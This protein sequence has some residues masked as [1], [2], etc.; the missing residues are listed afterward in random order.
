MLTPS[1]T[2]RLHLSNSRLITCTATILSSTPTR[3]VLEKTP[4][5]HLVGETGTISTNSST[6][7]VD[8]IED[9][10]NVVTH[11]GAWSSGEVP[12]PGSFVTASI[13]LKM[14]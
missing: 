5:H 2:L 11:V 13:T 6:F 3:I 1:T 4:F 10:G 9:D 7:F 12:L 8:G 14:V